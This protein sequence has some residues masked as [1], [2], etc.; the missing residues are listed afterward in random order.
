MCCIVF[1]LVL[2]LVWDITPIK[3]GHSLA[4]ILHSTTLGATKSTLVPPIHDSRVCYLR[5]PIVVESAAWL[6][7]PG[8]HGTRRPAR[9]CTNDLW[10]SL[11]GPG[12]YICIQARQIWYEHFDVIIVEVE[13]VL[14]GLREKMRLTVLFTGL[15]LGWV[16][17]RFVLIGVVTRCFF[18]QI[19]TQ[20]SRKKYSGVSR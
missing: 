11:V 13:E 18:A 6:A 10:P 14:G 3:Q 9:H 5:S 1:V 8:Y 2:S 16:W 4:G 15:L 20:C 12:R 7:W 17:F 19:G